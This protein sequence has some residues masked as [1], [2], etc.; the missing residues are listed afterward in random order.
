MAGSYEVPKV[1][2]TAPP[3]KLPASTGEI[4][5]LEKVVSARPVVLY[6]YPKADTP[7]CT[8]EA[9]GFRD[10]RPDYVKAGVV[11]LG[12]SPD[13][14]EK[15]K[16]F[17]EKFDLNFPLLADAD[18][19][20]CDRYGAWQEKSMYGRKYWGAARMTFII[21]KGGKILHVF[22]KVK[23]EGHEREVLEWLAASRQ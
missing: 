1:G 4:I 16:K 20:V 5:D 13:P 7:G 17:A 6:F 8:K 22:E 9:C 15:V 14:I 19:A 21:G 3:F 2:D 11:V 18:H 10:A 12:I 23:P